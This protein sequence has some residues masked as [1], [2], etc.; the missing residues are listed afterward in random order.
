M[1]DEPEGS[2]PAE[3]NV[4]RETLASVFGADE[5]R[6]ALAEG[7]VGLLSTIGIERGLIGP[8]EV[9]RLWGRHVLGS[10][11]VE[12]LIPQESDV[13]DVGSGGGLPG[14]PLAIARP[15]IWVTLVEPMQRRI[16]FLEEVVAT[17][18][19]TN[20]E[21]VRARADEVSPRGKADI[22]VSRAVAPLGKLAGWCL[23]LARLGGLMLAIKGQSAEE[24]IKR[25]AN[26]IRAL[27]GAKASIL[28]CGE[29]K[30][31]EPVFTVPVTVVEIER[32]H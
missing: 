18:G 4:S 10:A 29:Y 32:V 5:D 28:Q 30:L 31:S 9:P 13:I 19:L 17:L 3:A 6:I 23:P 27:G 15:D 8:R 16:T 1:N 20:I 22:V 11:V 12:E 25:D 21:V 7:Y 24:E 14:I 26:A 2:E